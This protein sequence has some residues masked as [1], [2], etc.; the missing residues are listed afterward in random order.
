MRCS[1]TLTDRKEPS[2]TPPSYVGGGGMGRDPQPQGVSCE[3][4]PT[5]LLSQP[6]LSILCTLGTGEV[7]GDLSGVSSRWDLF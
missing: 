5:G 1:A 2:A 3:R 6:H 7:L 4:K